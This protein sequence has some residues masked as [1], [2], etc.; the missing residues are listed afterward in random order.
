MGR[1][2]YTLSGGAANRRGAQGY[3]NKRYF[4]I[5]QTVTPEAHCTC[6]A[7]AGKHQY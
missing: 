2:G 7:S 6:C 1:L 5:P 4:V 3:A